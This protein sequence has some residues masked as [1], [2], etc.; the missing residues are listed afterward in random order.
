VGLV[1]PWTFCW[2][3]N[4]L[5]EGITLVKKGT[6]FPSEVFSMSGLPSVRLR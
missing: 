3:V 5:I 1:P 2:V 6:I 4:L